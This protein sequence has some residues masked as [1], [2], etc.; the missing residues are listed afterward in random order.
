[1]TGSTKG[2]YGEMNPA[3]NETALTVVNGLTHTYVHDKSPW[4]TK[5]NEHQ[6]VSDA[7]CSVDVTPLASDGLGVA[8]R[9][10]GHV[11]FTCVHVASTAIEGV[12]WS[13]KRSPGPDPLSDPRTSTMIQF[14][15]QEDSVSVSLLVRDSLTFLECRFSMGSALGGRDGCHT[16]HSAVQPA[17]ASTALVPYRTNL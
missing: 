7:E 13:F 15:W 6:C 5:C 12:D 16:S 14:L 9:R 1:M 11:G 2:T 8:W 4:Q 3:T 17:V 10:G